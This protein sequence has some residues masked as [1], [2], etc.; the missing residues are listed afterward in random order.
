MFQ[1]HIAS[2]FA[3]KDGGDMVPQNVGLSEL[4]DTTTQKAVLFKF[5]SIYNQACMFNCE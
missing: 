5:F 4:C 3:L 1:E 2:V